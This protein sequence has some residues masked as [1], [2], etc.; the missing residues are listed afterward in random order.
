MQANIFR[1]RLA[2]LPP[3]RP[4]S[5]RMTSLETSPTIDSAAAGVTHAEMANALRALAMDAVEAAKSGHPGMP[6]GMADVATVL[7]TKFLKFDPAD[8]AWPDRDRFILSAGH[9]SMLLYALLHLT[10]Y[11]E[12]TLEQLKN[13]RQLGSITAGHPEHGAAGGIETTTGPLGQGFANSVGMALAERHLA[14]RFGAE[15]V[16]HFTYVIASDGDLM[17][18]ISHE[19]AALAG[20]LALSRLVVLYDDNHISIDGDTAL[21][22]T[23]D[24]LARFAAYGWDT[25]AVSGH[26]PAAIAA[27]L[28]AA[29]KSPRPSLIACRTTIAYG[30]PTKAGSAASHGSPLGEKEIAGAREKLGWPHAP[31]VIPAP[32]RDAWRAA[33]ARGAA[34]HR[35][36]RERLG[37]ADP[38]TRDVFMRAVLGALPPGWLD[39]LNA[40]KRKCAEDAVKWA[41][42]KSSGEAL[43]VLTEVIPELVGG[44]ADLT[45]SN[46]TL[47][48]ATKPLSRTNYGGRYIHYGVREHGMAAAMNGM[49]LHGGIIPYAGTFLIFSDYLRPSLRLSALMEQRV[50]YVLTHDSIGLGEDGPTHQP[51]EH[52][53]A[54]R[55]IPRLMVFRPADAVETAECWALA[56]EAHDRP[57]AMALTRQDLP[58]LRRQHT[59]EN[60]CARGAYVLAEEPGATVTL[61]ATG[62]EVQIAFEARERLAKQ[63][64]A[65][66][67]VSMPC[68]ELFEEQ[69]GAY[70]D[71]VLG[72]GTARVAIEAAARMGWDRYLGEFGQFVGM[73]GFGASAPASALYKH[74]GITAEAVVEAAHH[75]LGAH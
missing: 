3:D 20:H 30:A 59:D 14:A 47:T 2:Q 34:P 61:L 27:A 62:S 65:A 37:D 43:E 48:K 16:D 52:L 50:I 69:P 32:I 71:Y 17:E 13:F 60:L 44:S 41:T 11:A 5:P 63:Q 49:A 58:A 6:M 72:P 8:P 73:T 23:E 64:I 29:R 9:G 66:R 28:A 57:S 39:K 4:Y 45:G 42:R 70:R 7:F 35:A 75:A 46:N 25:A 26:D 19:A 74:F 22:M 33:G 15:L 54:L 51:V 18:G 38:A 12:M 67:V 1:I 24:V 21:A 31:F 40:H 56:L 53:A 10:G 36:W 68:W 55:A